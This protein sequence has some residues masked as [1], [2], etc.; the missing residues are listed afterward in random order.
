MRDS[1]VL[2]D[3]FC[4]WTDNIVNAT[5]TV[6]KYVPSTATLPFIYLTQHYKA[7][8]TYTLTF[9]SV[10][11]VECEHSAC[12]CYLRA[13]RRRHRLRRPTVLGMEGG[14]ACRVREVRG[15]RLVRSVAFRRLT[16]TRV[17]HACPVLS[18]YQ[19]LGNS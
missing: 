16:Y 13:P 11:S 6:A 3:T 1:W 2:H 4:D 7:T 18:H 17:T 19:A 5:D 12:L 9:N 15:R 14:G 10:K 8:H